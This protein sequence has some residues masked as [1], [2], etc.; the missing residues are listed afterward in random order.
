M[1]KMPSFVRVGALDYAVSEEYEDLLSDD[2]QLCDGI[3]TQCDQRIRING[4]LLPFRK[5]E[6]LLHEISHAIW[7]TSS[8][9]V[10]KMNEEAFACVVGMRM[11]EVFKDNASLR[12]WIDEVCKAEPCVA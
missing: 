3:I 1:P 10:F 11:S 6:V 5:V 8:L 4:R 9:D 12:Q 2:G 7:F